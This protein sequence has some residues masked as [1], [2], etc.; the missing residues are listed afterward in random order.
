MQGRVLLLILCLALA[1]SSRAGEGGAL[2]LRIDAGLGQLDAEACHDEPVR[3][4]LLDERG[5]EHLRDLRFVPDGGVERVIARRRTLD[6]PAG[7][8]RW[9]FSLDDAVDA[10]HGDSARRLGEAVALSPNFF[11]YLDASDRRPRKV[12]LVLPEGIG[13]SVPWT[14]TDTDGRGAGLH[15]FVP[16]PRGWQPLV[17]FGKIEQRRI[18]VAGTELRLAV[19]AGE[20][21]ADVEMLAEWI[22]TA[23]RSLTT[24]T[25]TFPVPSPQVLVVP[26]VGSPVMGDRE[27]GGPVPFARVLR[28]GGAALQFFVD[29][30]RGP[31]ALDADW[32]AA[33]EFAHLLLPFIG[34]R[35]AWISEGFASYY[36]NVLRARTGQ[37]TQQEAWR[38]LAEGFDRGRGADYEKTL[39][40]SITE[41]GENRTMR[42]YWTGA[43]V[44]L[45]ADVRLRRAGIEGGL[46]S[47][48]ARLTHC[49]L[50]ADRAW[51]GRELFARLDALSG[52]GIFTALY[53]EVVDS[54]AFPEVTE[55]W[56]A[57]GVESRGAT[58]RFAGDAASRSLRDA[59]MTTPD[60]RTVAT[61]MSEAAEG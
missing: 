53:D 58:L 36:Q 32:T 5:R 59:I 17:V 24:V 44:A 33:H 60:A 34:Q 35:D 56:A 6:L 25:G 3:L 28:D 51:H 18:S 7:C 23:A 29:Q 12:E 8:L 31:A 26:V 13:A 50:P 47:V 43:A 52:T 22:A 9:R 54:T 45:L 40:A 2:R 48:L 55:A 21:A 46:D 11:L 14:P 10:E 1:G 27:P 15:R 4:R 39:H 19:L 38:K 57:L 61:G 42:L 37:L 20:P 16:G 49:C 41:G 30:R